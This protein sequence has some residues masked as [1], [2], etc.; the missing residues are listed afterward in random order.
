MNEIR[1]LQDEEELLSIGS[2]SILPENRDISLNNIIFQYSPNSP[3]VLTNI[4]LTIPQN[5]VTAIV[6]G[7]GSGKSTLLKLLVRL[8]K[9]TFG[10][11]KNL[12]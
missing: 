11:I 7:S 9:P 1:Q 6:G 2:T 5:K 8:Y 3:L 12:R 10:E 4:Y